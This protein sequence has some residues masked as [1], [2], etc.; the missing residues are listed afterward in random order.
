METFIKPDFD[1]VWPTYEDQNQRKRDRSYQLR[2]N[3]L[4][5]ISQL[6]GLRHQV[7]TQEHL[8]AQ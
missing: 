7:F 5:I 3:Q 6:W 1:Y 8:L 2:L 4:D